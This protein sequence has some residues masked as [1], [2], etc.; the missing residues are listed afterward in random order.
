M[1]N[2]I[3]SNYSDFYDIFYKTKDYKSEVNYLLKLI[4]NYK[5]NSHR[6]LEFG[7]GTGKHAKILAKVG[8][9]VHGIEKSRGMISQTKRSK[10]FTCSVGDICNLDLGI[11]FDT[12]F[13][14]FHVM[15]Y[16]T[17]NSQI[18]GAFKSAAKHLHKNGLFIFDT[19]FSS[20]VLHIKPSV[21]FRKIKHK[22]FEI[23]R[24]AEPKNIPNSNIVDIHYT[25]LIKN[26]KN[27]T[28]KTIT[29]KHSMRHYSIPEL[30]IMAQNHSFKHIN[31][32][33]FL[34]SNTPTKNTWTICNIFKKI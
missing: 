7:S 34:T 31:S 27:N 19:W 12:V 29:E 18:N 9:K 32:E 8:F 10:N 13:S 15:S 23:F 28:L 14:L 20:G 17:S 25:I 5:N 16:Q 1:N 4:K 11:K 26:I 22:N 30:K 24:I 21:K 2:N 3:F 6:L 33:E